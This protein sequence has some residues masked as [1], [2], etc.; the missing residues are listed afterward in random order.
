MRRFPFLFVLV[1]SYAFSVLD[2]IFPKPVTLRQHL[3][4][5][6]IVG[7]I[8]VCFITLFQDTESIRNSRE[9]S[10]D[11]LINMNRGVDI[12]KGKESVPFVY[13]DIDDKTQQLWGE[14]LYT[15]REKLA[16][17]ITK[18]LDKRPAVLVVD[19]ELRK[20]TNEDAGLLEV[21][22]THAATADA[23]ML[24]LV[25][26]FRWNEGEAG[27]GNWVARPSFID[28]S[29][30]PSSRR[31]WA[32]PLFEQDKDG[33]YRRW[34]SWLSACSVEGTPMIVPSVQLSV[35]AVLAG[36]QGI[37]SLE[38]ALQSAAPRSCNEQASLA[39]SRILIGSTQ[40]D[41]AANAF[42][43][44]ILF[45]FP[46]KLAADEVR[47]LVDFA[48]SKTRLL[49]ILPAHAIT[50]G[51]LDPSLPPGHI[52]VIGASNQ[53][54]R[55]VHTTPL[56]LM[57]G[58]LILIN[59]IHSLIQHGQLAAPP[60]WVQLL[61]ATLLLTAVSYIFM[62]FPSTF[63]TFVSLGA[64]IVVLVPASM[65]LFRYGIWLDF[66]FPIAAVKMFE[67]TMGYLRKHVHDR[68]APRN[69]H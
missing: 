14:P 56:G 52:A 7:L 44:R 61:T 69:A 50:E 4:Q 60:I 38:Q 17:L 2:R 23:P 24:I 30:P 11:W 68:K 63:G 27:R 22:K 10:I 13:Y 51:G 9:E 36:D 46:R 40:I 16:R 58:S 67:L 47:P 39:V 32:S 57:S 29:L 59:A 65:Y 62:K 33:Q 28:T 21:L 49:T 6:L 26:S 66:A 3:R 19:V 20:A 48:G 1:L 41:V 42:T 5:N 15:P 45:A 55:D 37:S 43:Q 25:Q 12:V 64:L 31:L 54:A 35:L 53:D 8:V 34:R 18:A